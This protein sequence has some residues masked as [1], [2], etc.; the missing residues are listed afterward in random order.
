MKEEEIRKRRIENEERQEENTEITMLLE[1]KMEDCGQLYASERHHNERVI[2]YFYRQEEG[3]FFEEI[4]EDARI[5]ERRFF[6]E[7]TDG[8]ETLAKNKRQL[9]E[10]SETLYEA[11][12]QALREEEDVHGQN[13]DW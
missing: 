11:E 1:R 5:E 13:G 2:A 12:L 9:E 3:T 10:H 7:I 4:I 8:Q 6:E